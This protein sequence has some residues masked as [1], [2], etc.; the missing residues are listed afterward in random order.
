MDF[1]KYHVDRDRDEII[2]T[3][4]LTHDTSSFAPRASREAQS[5]IK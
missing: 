1:R 3:A 2:F 4:F 5:K